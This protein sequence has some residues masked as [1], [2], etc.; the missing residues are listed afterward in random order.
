MTNAVPF[1]AANLKCHIDLKYVEERTWKYI[2]VEHASVGNVESWNVE[3]FEHDFS[4]PFS[5]RLRVPCRFSYEDGMFRGITAHDMRN[6]VINQR[7]DRTE[8]VY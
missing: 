8:V 4:H 5:A 6:S 3:F 7:F 1:P 2:R